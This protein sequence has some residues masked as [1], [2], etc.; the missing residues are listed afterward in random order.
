MNDSIPKKKN[1]II[2]NLN[3]LDYDEETTEILIDFRDTEKTLFLDTTEETDN[4]TWP[5]VEDWLQFIEHIESDGSD[6]LVDFYFGKE[7]TESNW[8]GFK[9]IKDENQGP[10]FQRLRLIFDN[11][12]KFI[13]GTI[14][15]GDNVKYVTEEV[16]ELFCDFTFSGYSFA[17]ENR[18][19]QTKYIN[20][21]EISITD[22]T[23]I[24]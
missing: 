23:I 17:N 5:K 12:M 15:F 19:L 10:E 22:I 4:G 13:F 3:D 2:T 8:T 1:L 6:A 9:L 18:K 16:N 14:G 11:P 24:K 20:G 21:L 7:K